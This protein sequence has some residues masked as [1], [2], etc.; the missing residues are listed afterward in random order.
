[1]IYVYLGNVFSFQKKL[2]VFMVNISSC[3]A[4]TFCFFAPPEYQEYRA[5]SL[6]KNKLFFRIQNLK[7]KD[8][9]GFEG[10]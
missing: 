8:A 9:K 4:K 7:K 5:S 1:M 6:I 2:K 3:E 10:C